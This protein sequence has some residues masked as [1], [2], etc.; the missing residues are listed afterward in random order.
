MLGCR[1]AKKQ[2]Q[3]REKGPAVVQRCS[4]EDYDRWLGYERS[5]VSRQGQRI[6]EHSGWS[7]AVV[8]V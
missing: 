7:T 5:M 2:W 8:L 4:Q 3:H 6:N 1:G